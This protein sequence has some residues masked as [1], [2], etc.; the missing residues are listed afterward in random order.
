MKTHKEEIYKNRS[1][2]PQ[3]TFQQTKKVKVKNK[4]QRTPNNWIIKKKMEGVR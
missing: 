2:L 1:R 4:L 3:K